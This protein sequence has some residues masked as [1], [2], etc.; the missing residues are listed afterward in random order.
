[1]QA[2][3]VNALID[4]AG[5]TLPMLG[6]WTQLPTVVQGLNSQGRHVAFPKDRAPLFAFIADRL[7]LDEELTTLNFQLAPNVD[8]QLYA[9]IG[10]VH[11]EHEPTSIVFTLP[12][13]P[14]NV[15][16]AITAA[17]ENDVA[18]YLANLDD[19]EAEEAAHLHAGE[20]VLLHDDN[21]A[22]NTAF[23][24]VLVLRTASSL[25]LRDICDGAQIGQSTMT[26]LLAMPVTKD[27]LA[28]RR[29][30]GHDALMDYFSSTGREVAFYRKLA[31]RSGLL[32]MGHASGKS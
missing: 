10:H 9:G 2:K 30:R 31:G 12:K 4:V 19:Y 3:G 14:G 8:I 26:F 1:M 32:S 11:D 21:G 18:R 29:D 6:W 24:G 13:H 16:F 25:Y 27:D 15:F 7:P 22:P 28:I 5:T 20:V 17:N 23:A